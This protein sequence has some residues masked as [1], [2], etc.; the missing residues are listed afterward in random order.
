MR[1][2]RSSRTFPWARSCSPSPSVADLAANEMKEVDNDAAGSRLRAQPEPRRPPDALGLPL[3]HR[4]PRREADP[5]WRLRVRAGCARGRWTSLRSRARIPIRSL[6][7]LCACTSRF[8]RSTR[9]IT[10]RSSTRRLA[11]RSRP[12]IRPVSTR[13]RPRPVTWTRMQPGASSP[14][15]ARRRAAQQPRRQ[16]SRTQPRAGPPALGQ[17]VRS[18]SYGSSGGED[19]PERSLPLWQRPQVQVLLPA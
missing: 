15:R 18:R 5:A 9:R 2:G 10:A 14:G 12:A 7:A 8:E 1:S 19:G 11:P 6:P 17:A 13:P 4:R 16:A 3:L